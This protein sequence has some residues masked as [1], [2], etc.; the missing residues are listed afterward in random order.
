MRFKWH[1]VLREGVTLCGRR[2]GTYALLGLVT[3]LPAIVWWGLAHGWASPAADLLGHQQLDQIPG[4]TVMVIFQSL[5]S[6]LVVAAVF[7]DLRGRRISA[8]QSLRATSFNV[9]LLPIVFFV[10]CAAAVS[11]HFALTLPLTAYLSF[12]LLEPDYRYSTDVVLAVMRSTVFAYLLRALILLALTPL[13]VAAPCIVV[14]R[15]NLRD[16]LRRS[17]QLTA[18]RR[19]MA[20]SIV[21]TVVLIP[22]ILTHLVSA[23]IPNPIGAWVAFCVLSVASTAVLGTTIAVAYH[24]LRRDREWKGADELALSLYPDSTPSTN[25]SLDEPARL[26]NEQN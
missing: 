9:E 13:L 25:A 3:A 26:Q 11:I 15:L 12:T 4:W 7:D 16:G 21:A 18:G 14:E 10:Q 20:F 2:V 6:G 5:C 24:R 1:T 8:W 17:L 23:A 22:Q 19:L